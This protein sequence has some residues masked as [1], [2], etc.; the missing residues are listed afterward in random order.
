MSSTAKLRSSEFNYEDAHKKVDILFID[1]YIDPAKSLAL[2]NILQEKFQFNDA[3]KRQLSS[4]LPVVIKHKTDLE[5]AKKLIDFISQLGGDCWIQTA[6]AEGYSDRRD[7][8][9][10]HT[11]D[12]RLLHRGWAIMPDRRRARERRVFFH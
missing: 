11:I 9:R 8:N 4:G 2:L 5:S 1:K 10:R 7:Q 12:R 6:S 3:V